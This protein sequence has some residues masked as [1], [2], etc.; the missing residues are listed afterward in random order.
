MHIKIGFEEKP[1]L[2]GL[3]QE[4]GFSQQSPAKLCTR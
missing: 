2:V 1:A 4:N 3:A